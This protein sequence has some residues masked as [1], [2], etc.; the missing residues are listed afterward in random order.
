MSSSEGSEAFLREPGRPCLGL[1][2][3]L[4]FSMPAPH[5]QCQPCHRPLL[6]KA[7]NMLSRRGEGAMN[8]A[9]ALDERGGL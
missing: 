2:T 6:K 8:T 9:E 1:P 7:E 3:L 4:R 5:S